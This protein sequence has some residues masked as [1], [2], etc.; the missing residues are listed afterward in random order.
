MARVYSVLLKKAL[1]KKPSLSRNGA[2]QPRTDSI[3]QFY[4]LCCIC[5]CILVYEILSKQKLRTFEEC[6]LTANRLTD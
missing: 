3:V 5:I 4:Y 6:N 1:P 2:T